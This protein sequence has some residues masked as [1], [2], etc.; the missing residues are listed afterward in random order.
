MTKQI[1]SLLINNLELSV[2][3]GWPEKERAKKQIVQVSIE[4]FFTKPPKACVSD[5]LADTFCY[6]D[7]IKKLKEKTSQKQFYLIEHL[8]H[9]IYAQIKQLISMNIMIHLTK[10]PKISGLRNGVCFSYGDKE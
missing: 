7:L 6:D 9:E 1:A 4:F 5:D 2:H 8:A 10:K 3:L